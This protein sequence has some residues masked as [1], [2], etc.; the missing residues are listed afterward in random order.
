MIKAKMGFATAPCSTGK[1][2]KRA[3]NILKRL[4][5]T[6]SKVTLRKLRAKIQLEAIKKRATPV[7]KE[8]EKKDAQ[9]RSHIPRAASD[10]PHKAP[11]IITM[12]RDLGIF[13]FILSSFTV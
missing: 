3:S 12:P 2:S 1:E 11:S 6:M 9:L 8:P 10:K 7:I 5:I 13:L 4:A